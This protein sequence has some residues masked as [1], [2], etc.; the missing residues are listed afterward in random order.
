[1]ANSEKMQAAIMQAVIQ[2]AT[3][4]VKA[5]READPPAEPHTRRSISEEHYR[6]GQAR[7]M[8]SQPAFNWKVPHRY[9]ELLKL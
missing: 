6:P 1:M 8:M 7:P 4:V 2:A 5:M 9:V 3:V